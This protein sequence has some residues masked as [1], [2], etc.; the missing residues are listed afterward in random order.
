MKTQ[1]L[2]SVTRGPLER[3]LARLLEYGTYV[4]CAVIASGL[5]L[6]NV[7]ERGAGPASP[8]LLGTHIVTVG[9]AILLLLPAVRV[10]LM[11]AAFVRDREY[12]FGFAAAF[13]LV[14]IVLGFMAGMLSSKAGA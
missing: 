11:L 4:A 7:L 3:W 6:A 13:V 14:V 2:P 10:T 8:S 12:R 5:V 1:R 9:I